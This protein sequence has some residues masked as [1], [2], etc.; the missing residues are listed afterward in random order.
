MFQPCLKDLP[1]G[2]TFLVV[3][4]LMKATPL[5]A[6]MKISLCFFCSSLGFGC[7]LLIH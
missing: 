6:F 5:A 4:I 3:F 2:V 7:V 1:A